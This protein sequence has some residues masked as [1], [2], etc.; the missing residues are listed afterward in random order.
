[1]SIENPKYHTKIVHREEFVSFD[2]IPVGSFFYY[3]RKLYYKT[4]IYNIGED[5]DYN[6]ISIGVCGSIFF[7]GFEEVVPVK[8]IE[9]RKF[10]G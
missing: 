4:Y 10:E 3:E 8:E 9:V 7:D 6:A 2:E 5:L 1:M